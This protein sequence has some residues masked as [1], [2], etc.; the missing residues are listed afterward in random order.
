[1]MKTIVLTIILGVGIVQ[2]LPQQTLT[3]LEAAKS[4]IRWLGALPPDE[5]YSARFLDIREDKGLLITRNAILASR[6]GGLNW[7]KVAH[8]HAPEALNGIV[9]AWLSSSNELYLLSDS[10]SLDTQGIGFQVTLIPTQKG[11]QSSMDIDGDTKAGTIIAVGGESVPVTK[12]RFVG[13]PHY[14]Q[15]SDANSPSMT[16]PIISISKDK[17]RTWHSSRF[18]NAMG[19]LDGIRIFGANAIAWG[20]YEI[21]VSSDRGLSWHKVNTDIPDGEEDAYPV[22][23]TIVGNNTYVS[24]KS[25]RLLKGSVVSASLLTVSHIPSPLTNLTFVNERIGFGVL[26]SDQPKEKREESQLMKTENGGRTWAPI[27]KTR[28]IVAL[29]ASEQKLCGAGYDRVFCFS[30]SE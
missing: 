12:D 30:L 10:K 7:D 1:M 14:A 29:S 17:A 6:D 20:P 21:F 8:V 18:K 2:C 9:G 26:P 23:A 27:L 16:V 11:S 15:G 19:Y 3:P 28:R 22:S 24:T 13:L 4:S 25:G 5:F